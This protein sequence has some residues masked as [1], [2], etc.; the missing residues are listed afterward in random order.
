MRRGPRPK[1]PLGQQN[2]DFVDLGDQVNKISVLLSQRAR[3][4]ASRQP[5]DDHGQHDTRSFVGRAAAAVGCGCV[6]HGQPSIGAPGEPARG[7]AAAAFGGEG[8]SLR[9]AGDRL[10]W[11]VIA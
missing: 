3:G 11:G 1:P 2:A 10:S 5:G 7:G 8:R 9:R 6:G 4:A